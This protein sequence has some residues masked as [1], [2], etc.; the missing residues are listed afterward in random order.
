MLKKSNNSSPSRQRSEEQLELKRYAEYE[1]KIAILSQEIERM[2]DSLK[3]RDNKLKSYEQE[4]ELLRRRQ[5]DQ[6]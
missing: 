5:E 6:L 3:A 2:N 4:F 1:N